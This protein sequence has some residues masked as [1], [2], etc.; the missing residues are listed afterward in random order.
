MNFF[1]MGDT[2]CALMKN[3]SIRLRREMKRK[4]ELPNLYLKVRG[5]ECS[6][7]CVSRDINKDKRNEGEK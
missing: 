2:K 3:V 4:W 1:V 5:D 6:D 7:A